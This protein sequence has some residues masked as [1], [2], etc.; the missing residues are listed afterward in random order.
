MSNIIRSIAVAALLAIPAISFAQS[1]D[2][3]TRAS[4]HADLVR[5][6]AAGYNPGAGEDPNYPADLQAAEAK[7]AMQNNR[8]T[9]M[10]SVGGMPAEGTSNSGSPSQKPMAAHCTGP[11]AFCDIYFGS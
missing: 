10:S 8:S 7:V 6:E 9:V 5:L 2:S 3:I 4:V 11:I 1:T